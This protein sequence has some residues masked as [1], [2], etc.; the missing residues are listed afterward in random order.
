MTP[1]ST[2]KTETKEAG[3]SAAR[4]DVF[5][6]NTQVGSIFDTS[7]LSF[8]YAAAWLSSA[9]PAA[10]ANIELRQGLNSSAAVLAFFENLLPEGELRSY[11]ASAEKAS[12][13][14]ALLRQ[15]AG[16][17][18]GGFVI[19]PAGQKVAAPAYEPTSWEALGKILSQKSAA[20]IDLKSGDGV[21]ISL[22]GA[23]DK[24]LI[25]I[26]ADGIPQLPRG[27]SPS[28]HILKPDIKRLAKVWESAANES[29]VMLAAAACGLPTAEVFYEPL[30]RA[31]IVKRFDRVLR[32]D[33]G[34][35]RL[36]QYDFCQLSD[37]P[38]DKKYESEGGPG[39]SDCVQLIRRHSTA[40]AADLKNFVSW[41][42]FNLYTGNNDSHAKNL[43]MYE[44]LG[45]GMRLT[46]FYDLMCTR[47]Y[48]GLSRNF[49]FAI[50]GE[51][52]PGNITHEH[53]QQMAKDM[54][55]GA[56]Y[57]LKLAGDVEKKIPA[58]M[59]AATLGLQPVL[60]YNAKIAA[61]RLG[62]FVIDNTRKMNTRLQASK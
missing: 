27:T 9:K 55:M 3:K 29:I 20:A 37:L 42:F 4:L 50:G 22:A 18:V 26:F 31:C 6:G 7:P 51:T 2:N 30:T 54:D 49:A 11:I 15:V 48:P 8:E 19:M 59:E 39:I 14:F 36:V 52:L 60:S 44:V 1:D 62:R 23:Q 38:S 35:D 25:A 57:V 21:R 41:L 61:T 56:A 58:A 40:P 5:F 10:L 43:S 34:L 32:A 17:T 24:A 45:Q 53:V 33:G 12:S 47:L 46:P 13:I 16:D 28:T